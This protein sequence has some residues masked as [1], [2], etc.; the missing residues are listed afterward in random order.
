MTNPDWDNFAKLG[1]LRAV[2]DQNDKQEFKNRLI[3]R[4]H[5]NSIKKA[6]KDS[7]TLLDFGCGT[8]RFASNI[9]NLGIKYTG[10]DSSANMVKIA[11]KIHM[12]LVCN[13]VH[14]NGTDIPLLKNSFDSCLSVYVFQYI[15]GSANS[16]DILGDIRRVL[17]PFGRLIMIEQASLSNQTSGTV[18][19]VSTESDYI[20]ELSKYFYVKTVQRIRICH[21]SSLSYRVFH[22]GKY[23]PWLFP[24]CLNSL[25]KI[26]IRRAKKADDI[27]FR[28][29]PYYDIIIEAEVRG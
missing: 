18:T 14:F 15:I 3:D 6:L 22:I 24:F 28:N 4:I 8:G 2:L 16:Q 23:F 9:L 25:A 10:I 29:I 19:R 13:F 1:K 12:P 26:E 7:G 20:A 21:L 5:F 11:R 27:Y 17:I